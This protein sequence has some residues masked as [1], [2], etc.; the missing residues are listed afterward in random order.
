MLPL[1]AIILVFTIG[2]NQESTKEQKPAATAEESIQGVQL[3][4]QMPDS[5]T[6][7]F[8][9]AKTQ[10]PYKTGGFKHAPLTMNTNFGKLEFPGGYP[11]EETVQKVYDELD[12]QKATQLYLSMYPALSMKGMI[13]GVVRDYGTHSSSHIAV[14]A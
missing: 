5:E 13:E 7:I 14:T 8:D 12:L 10:T 4:E 9:W 3:S 1:I 11:T 6:S 2:C